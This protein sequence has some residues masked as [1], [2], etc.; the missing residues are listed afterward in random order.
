MSIEEFKPGDVVVLKSDSEHKM[1][2]TIKDVIGDRAIC[3]YFDPIKF[4]IK[5]LE[6]SKSNGIPLVLLKKI[7]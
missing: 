2:M 6:I 3:L 1:K 4:D 7:D 5:T